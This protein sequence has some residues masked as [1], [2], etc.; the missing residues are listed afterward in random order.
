MALPTCPLVS[1]SVANLLQSSQHVGQVNSTLKLPKIAT[2]IN[3]KSLLCPQLQTYIQF[4]LLLTLTSFYTSLS[5]DQYTPLGLASL[6]FLQTL[7]MITTQ[8]FRI[9]SFVC[10]MLVPRRFS[11][12]IL[13]L[14]LFL[15]CFFLV[16]VFFIILC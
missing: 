1:V 11:W 3:T 5:F 12:F 13:I 7:S 16:I 10:L 15:F 6:R 8:G 2:L 4:S 14:F 9:F